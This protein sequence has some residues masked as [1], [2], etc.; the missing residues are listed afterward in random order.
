M[1][2]VLDR[3][4]P[5]PPSY[6]PGH[7]RLPRPLACDYRRPPALVAPSRWRFSPHDGYM[8]VLVTV[9]TS[10]GFLRW[11][12]SPEP[13]LPDVLHCEGYPYGKDRWRLCAVREL[14]GLDLE[15]SWRAAVQLVRQALERQLNRKVVAEGLVP[16]AFHIDPLAPGWCHQRL[17]WQTVELRPA[18]H[19]DLLCALAG[20]PMLPVL[21]RALGKGLRRHRTAPAYAFQLHL[22][23]PVWHPI[24]WRRGGWPEFCG[25]VAAALRIET[26]LPI[27]PIGNGVI[28]RQPRACDAA[29]AGGP[30]SVQLAPDRIAPRE[31]NRGRF[32]V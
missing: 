14:E 15:D 12:P 29:R 32:W 27:K 30:R 3:P 6:P 16:P 23:E 9:Y 4:S 17:Q 2:T 7:R 11:A 21:M 22:A 13:W 26:G 5:A 8:E 28:D 19:D 25:A 24:A 18:A 31:V 10:A 20:T 1:T